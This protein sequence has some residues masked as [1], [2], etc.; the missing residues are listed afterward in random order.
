M[1]E[2]LLDFTTSRMDD[3]SAE[4]RWRTRMSKRFSSLLRGHEVRI[5]TK[6]NS[7]GK[8]LSKLTHGLQNLADMV[9][10][11]AQ[12]NQVKS[13][14]VVVEGLAHSSQVTSS[15]VVVEGLAKGNGA[16]D[17]QLAQVRSNPAQVQ[18]SHVQSSP[19]HQP[20][21]QPANGGAQQ[22]EAP[23]HSRHCRPAELPTIPVTPPSTRA[24]AGRPP[25]TPSS[26][27]MGAT[28]RPIVIV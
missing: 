24:R 1:R 4:Q 22:A 19:A 17:E 25:V 14:Q 2:Y 10:G 23:P 7:Q 27:R 12:A 28:P 26:E 5:N 11:L 20:A 6:L 21:N 13:S 18:S 9:E 3:A 15:Q 8:A 16:S